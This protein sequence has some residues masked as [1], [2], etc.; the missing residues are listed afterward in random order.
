MHEALKRLVDAGWLDQLAT[1][2]DEIRGHLTIVERNLDEAQGPLKY[3]DSRFVFAYNA[4]LNAAIEIWLG[5]AHPE[6][7]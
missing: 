7:L 4:V 2:R 3:P 1:S 5:A 6:L